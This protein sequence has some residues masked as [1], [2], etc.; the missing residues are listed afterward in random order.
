MK[1]AGKVEV[2]VSQSAW[3]IDA[4][5]CLLNAKRLD[6]GADRF[7]EIRNRLSFGFTLTVGWDVRDAGREAPLLRVRDK[8][9][10]KACHE[11]ILPPS[12]SGGAESEGRI[13]L[14][15]GLSL[16]I[17]TKMYISMYT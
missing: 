5:E 12:I 11:L 1:W 8:L 13:V 15:R 9:D 14:W 17:R 2:Q 16:T 3:L 10:R 6:V 4:R 7:L